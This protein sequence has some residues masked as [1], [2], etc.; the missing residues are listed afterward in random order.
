MVGLSGVL[1]RSV[2]L[3][4]AIAVLALSAGCGG[5]GSADYSTAMQKVNDLF[6]Q[7]MAEDRA[8]SDSAKDPA[9]A[10]TTY[11]SAADKL[12]QAAK[13]MS[14]LP[15]PDA[16]TARAVG[17]TQAS[18]TMKTQKAHLDSAISKSCGT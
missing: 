15:P 14:D 3:S 18:D 13:I 17:W 1:G 8:A 4:A 10:C 12:A 7:A 9:T 16:E 2:F 5:K 11:K 6:S